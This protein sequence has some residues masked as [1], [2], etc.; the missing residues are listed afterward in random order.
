MTDLIKKHCSACEGDVAV[1]DEAMI[2]DYLSQ[3]TR[4]QYD[5]V[6]QSI[7]RIFSFANY[8]QTM[9]FVNAVAW[10]AHQ[11]D[12]HPDMLVGYKECQVSYKTHA[13]SGV[14]ENDFICA[15]KIDLIITNE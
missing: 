3:I 6:D 5:E 15:A 11:E 12:H 14:T 10:I 1:L 9:A 8:Y 2:Q 7:Y 4:W 13:V